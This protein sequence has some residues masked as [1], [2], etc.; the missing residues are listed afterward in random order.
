MPFRLLV[1]VCS[2]ILL[3]H[4]SVVSA[5]S[6]VPL[7]YPS[8]SCSSPTATSVQLGNASY[9]DWQTAAL[10]T[11]TVYATVFN[12]SGFG[13]VLSQ[14]VLPLPDN[15]GATGPAHLQLGV[16]AVG[17]YQSASQSTTMVLV[18]Q[19]ADITCILPAR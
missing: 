3:V 5:Q 10:Y 16:Y 14:I 13:A 18:G 17:P 8:M 12:S 11:S 19:T 15:S 1:A 4:L 6:Y 2:A 7:V 9:L